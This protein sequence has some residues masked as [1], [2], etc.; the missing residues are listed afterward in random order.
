M[1]VE[2]KG[3]GERSEGGKTERCGVRLERRSRRLREEVNDQK[4]GKKG[5]CGVRLERRSRSRGI[6]ESE[7]R[8]REG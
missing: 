6:D 3:R 8:E 2:A 1:W 4:E 5:R 7:A